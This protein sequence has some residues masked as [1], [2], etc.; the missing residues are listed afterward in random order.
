MES[1]KHKLI[2][3]GKESQMVSLESLQKT[4]A[5]NEEPMVPWDQGSCLVFE[6]ILNQLKEP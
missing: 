6:N 2:L 3:M 4:S 1:N 5:Y